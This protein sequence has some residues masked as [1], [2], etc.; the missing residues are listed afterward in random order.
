MV[1]MLKKKVDIV[2]YDF[3]YV[4]FKLSI[5]SFYIAVIEFTKRV[6]Q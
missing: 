2:P 1:V 6:I 5:M 3:F 4:G